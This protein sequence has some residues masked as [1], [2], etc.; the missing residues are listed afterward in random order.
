[1]PALKNSKRSRSSKRRQAPG[2]G[3][4]ILDVAFAA[5]LLTILSV[6][7][8]WWCHSRGYLL[9][10]GDAVSHLNT[11]RRIIDSRT[12]GIDQWGSPWLPLPHLLMIPFVGN[13]AWWRNGLAG[14]FP[15]AAC[16]I[17]A[18]VLLYLAARW[19]FESRAAAA[20]ALA[21]FALNP[22][23]LYMQSIPMTEAVFFATLMGVLVCTMWFARTQSLLA[24]SAAAVFVNLA[25]LSRYDGWF[26]APFAGLYILLMARE[27]RIAAAVVFGA[28][29]AIGPLAWLG[30]NFWYSG[31]ALDFYNGPYSHNAIYERALNAGMGRYAGDHDW[32]QAVQYYGAAAQLCAGTALALIGVLGIFAALLKR[33]F[34]PVLLLLLPCVFYVLSMY[35]GGSPIFVPHLWPNSYYNTRYG[36]V[37]VP[38]L[39]IGVAAIVAWMPPRFRGLAAVALVGGCMLPWLIYPRPDAWICW[40]ESE[41]NSIARRQWTRIAAD[42][43]KPRYRQ[44][45]GLFTSFGDLTGIFQEAGIPIRETLYDGNNPAW[46]GAVARPDLLLHEEWAVA[47]GGDSVA[48]AVQKA[49][50]KRPR[51]QLVEA[52][53]VKG[54]PV[55]EIYRRN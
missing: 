23:V 12:P 25:C 17:I 4:G 3:G 53:A 10:F 47:I 21:L 11:A 35:R 8:L 5:V 54:A 37:A 14:S 45:Q 1:M 36:L 24:A 16:F 7:A 6:A 38:L 51:Y 46:L 27:R 13:D 33:A 40:K 44:G 19:T 39:A 52:I 55:I 34:W 42:Y 22:N 26:I 31:N 48:T 20:T 41:V 30:Y 50:R 32:S 29:A 49:S 43:L 15:A 2:S 9:Y 18:G 28:I